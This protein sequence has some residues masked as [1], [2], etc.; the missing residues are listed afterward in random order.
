[1]VNEKYLVGAKP[2]LV[3]YCLWVND[4]DFKINAMKQCNFLRVLD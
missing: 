2:L 1:M 3:V 4:Q